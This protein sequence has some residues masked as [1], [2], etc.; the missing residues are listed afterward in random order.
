MVVR[1]V[2]EKFAEISDR[3]FAVTDIET[4][5]GQ[6][7]NNSIIELG[8]CF[9]KNN[10][11]MGRYHSLF[12]PDVRLPPFITKLTGITDDML[13]DAAQLSS[14]IVRIQ[15]LFENAVFVAH[16]VNFDYSFV[17]SAML[18]EG[19]EWNPQRLCTM[20]LARRAF[21]GLRSYGL[22]S[23][24]RHLG[25]VQDEAHRA[26]SDAETAA[27]I[28]IQSCKVLGEMEIGK[29]LVK[30]NSELFLPPGLSRQKF[31]SLPDVPGVYYL[32]DTAGVPLYI[33]KAIKIKS[34][35]RQHF[36][37]HLESERAQNFLRNVADIRYEL[38][39]N[40]LMAWLLEDVAIRTWMPKYNVAQKRIPVQFHVNQYRDQDKR[41]RF[42]IV[43]GRRT[44]DTLM[45]F[46]SMRGARNWLFHMCEEFSISTKL[47]GLDLFNDVGVNDASHNARMLDAI[48]AAMTRKV[49]LVFKGHG[50][51][52][53]ETSYIVYESDEN[54]WMGFVQSSAMHVDDLKNEL[55]K[56]PVSASIKAVLQRASEMKQGENHSNYLM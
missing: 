25:I 56:I 29:L 9:I 41:L 12:K 8:V 54:C 22:S 48:H 34:R 43:K 28:F 27:Q 50:R 24:A 19:L 2:A 33:G 14:E 55:T 7:H 32:L 31:D 45:S 20:R 5:G 47:A 17:R 3:V 16:N 39:G 6:P 53:D 51:D 40:E 44:S 11:L 13:Q 49:C 38:S 21:P 26:L 23:V 15:K 37:L 52:A 30:N 1:S 46:V 35:V 10:V 4:T 42:A 36:K 18:N